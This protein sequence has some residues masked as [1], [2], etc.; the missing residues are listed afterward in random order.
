MTSLNEPLRCSETYIF[1]P[2]YFECFINPFLNEVNCLF[3]CHILKVCMY[4]GRYTSNLVLINIERQE[5]SV[6]RFANFHLLSKYLKIFGN[7]F[8]VYLVLGF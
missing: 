4:V 5:F 7:I 8:M 3:R 6:T 2:T 1:V